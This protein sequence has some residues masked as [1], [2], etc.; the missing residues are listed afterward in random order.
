MSGHHPKSVRALSNSTIHEERSRRTDS[1]GRP[2]VGRWRAVQELNRFLACRAARLGRKTKAPRGRSAGV[3][4]D[5]LPGGAADDQPLCAGDGDYDGAPIQAAQMFG[6][7]GGHLAGGQAAAKGE[8]HQRQGV[9]ASLTG[10]VFSP[11]PQ[12]AELRG[13]VRRGDTGKGAHRRRHLFTAFQPGQRGAHAPQP[14]PV[15][16]GG[17][18][19]QV[20]AAGQDERVDRLVP[21]PHLRIVGQAAAVAPGGEPGGGV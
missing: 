10:Q 9:G 5:V 16:L 11:R 7:D 4:Q 14:A 20:G 13:G 21:Q 2:P 15:G 12:P 8:R 19:G 6:A 3:N 1:A 18:R 17:A